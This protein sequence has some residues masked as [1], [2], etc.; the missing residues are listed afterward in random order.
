MR[1]RYSAFVLGLGDYLVYSWHPDYLGGLNAHDLSH[2]DTQWDGLDIITSSDG[3]QDQT[4]IVEFKAWFQED[5]QRR[6]LH[7]RSQFVR[8]DGRWVYTNG[9]IMLPHKRHSR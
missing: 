9:E 3:A 4:G 5:G 2:I 1:S 7:E 8:F 6:C